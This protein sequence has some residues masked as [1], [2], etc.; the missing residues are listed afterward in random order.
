MGSYELESAL[1]V[2]PKGNASA[3][4]AKRVGSFVD[5]DIDVVILE[6]TKC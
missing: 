4:L 5:L 1:G 6:E 2:D 3:Y